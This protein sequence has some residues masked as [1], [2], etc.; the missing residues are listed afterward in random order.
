MVGARRL[1]SLLL[2]PGA[3]WLLLL[4][5]AP[6]GM[7]IAVS[8]GTTDILGRP[9]FGWYPENYQSAFDPLFVRVIVRSLVFAAT[10]TGLCLLIGYPVAYM[11]ARYAGRLRG[12]IRLVVHVRPLRAALDGPG[13]PELR[14][15]ARAFRV[16]L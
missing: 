16:R 13:A 1:W 5:V 14:P 7:V 4:F 11:I 9:I 2:L 3:F 8:L 10:T 6:F 12:R 15:F